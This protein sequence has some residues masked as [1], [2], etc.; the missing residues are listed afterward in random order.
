M[1]PPLPPGQLD[2]KPELKSHHPLAPMGA[3][4]SD[5]SAVLAIGLSSLLLKRM[6]TR[7]E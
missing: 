6:L 2:D 3:I 4:L 1:F 7:E 5:L